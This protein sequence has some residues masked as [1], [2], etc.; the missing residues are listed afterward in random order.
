MLNRNNAIVLLLMALWVGTWA[1]QTDRVQLPWV[2]S[3]VGTGPV[4]SIV[5][6]EKSKTTPEQSEYLINIRDWVSGQDSTKVQHY[7]FAPNAENADG[8][9]NENAKAIHDKIPTGSPLPHGLLIRKSGSR[10]VISWQGE[11]KS[12]AEYIDRMKGMID[13]TN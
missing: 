13:A 5:F 4:T 11:V 7:V 6:R 8:T 2:E 10:D 3:S 1:V 9:I 12:G